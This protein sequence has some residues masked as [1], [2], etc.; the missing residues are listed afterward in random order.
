MKRVHVLRLTCLAV[1]LTLTGCFEATKPLSAPGTVPYDIS[2]LGSWTCVPDPPLRPQ[3]KA[4]LTLRNIDQWTLD[5]NWVDGDKTSRYRVHGTK[6]DSVIVLNVLEVAP[7][8][9]WFFVRYKR[10]GNKLALS[11]ANG[12][13]IKGGYEARKMDDLKARAA[14]DDLFKTFAMCTRAK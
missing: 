1:A 5:A 4:T 6:V 2:V 14:G 12:Q 8:A 9:K 11:T 10:E 7:G 3:D 13:E